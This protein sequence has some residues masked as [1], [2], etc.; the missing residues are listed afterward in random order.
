MRVTPIRLRE[1]DPL[2]SLISTLGVLLDGI[3]T[4]S[5]CHKCINPPHSDQV[6]DA[7]LDACLSEDPLSKV[8]CETATK[9]GTL[10]SDYFR[11]DLSLTCHTRYDYGLR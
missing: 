6:S 10:I 4:N 8:A 3:Y 9:T 7:I 11:P 5:N 2:K 1:L